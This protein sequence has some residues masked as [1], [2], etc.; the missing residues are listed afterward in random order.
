MGGFVWFR[1]DTELDDE[2]RDYSE[3]RGAIVEVVE[4]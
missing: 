3:E 2:I 1:G 4:H